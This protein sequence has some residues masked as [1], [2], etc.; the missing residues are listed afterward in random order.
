MRVGYDPAVVEADVL[1]DYDGAGGCG[2]SWAGLGEG[3]EDVASRGICLMARGLVCIW[4]VER[5]Q[6]H[7]PAGRFLGRVQSVGVEVFV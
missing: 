5:E 3:I 1:R 6:Y 4:P 7:E 2:L